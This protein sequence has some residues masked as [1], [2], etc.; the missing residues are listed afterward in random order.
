MDNTQI[1][2]QTG[3]VEKAAA[4]VLSEQQEVAAHNFFEWLDAY[5]AGEPNIRPYFVLE[6]FAGTGKS[7]CVAELVRRTGLRPRYMT[8][9][10]K[11]ALVL[12]KYNPGLDARTI[13]SSIYRLVSVGDGTFKRLF[14]QL[15]KAQTDEARKEIQ[16]EI[17]D[18]R[19]PRFELNEEAFEDENIDLF[20]LDECSMV[21]QDILDDLLSFGL[22][23]IALGDPGQLPPVKGEGALFRG[24][25]DARLTEIR[26]QALDNPIIQ[27]SMWA[28]NSR[29]LPMTDPDQIMADRA[30]KCPKDLFSM[31]ELNQLMD[32]HDMTICWKNATRQFLNLMRRKH[33]GF[34]GQSNVYPVPGDTIIFTKNDRTAGV[35]NG[36]FATVVEVGNLMDMYI[37]LKVRL[38]TQAP[39]AEPIPVKILRACFEVY[40]DPDA[41]KSVKP[42]DYRDRQQCDYGYA[43]TC[44][45]A[46]GS[47]WD[48]VIVF[49]ENALNWPKA[50]DER[51]KWLYT[52][53]TRAAQ[54]I[55]IIAGK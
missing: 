54:K 17:D 13:H 31:D 53:V 35:L 37:E 43:I 46:Q 36:L 5:N 25:A 23:I 7:F 4:I 47:Q 22:P 39:D 32:Q 55:T 11:A 15:E 1:T 44:H 38:E 10:G 52:A 26:R 27:W 29:T 20:V 50:Q 48:R 40:V 24:L 30:A 21:N 19:K 34:Y 33:L 42:W 2:A 8:Y 28:R 41:W 12:N 16:K 45:K 18:L 14:E 49:E 3:A 9:T 6:G 51:A